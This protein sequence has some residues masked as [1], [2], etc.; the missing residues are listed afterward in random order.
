MDNTG[1]SVLSV[2]SRIEMVQTDSVSIEDNLVI[3]GSVVYVSIKLLLI[4]KDLK[5]IR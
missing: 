2:K 4:S 3:T 5:Y 1:I